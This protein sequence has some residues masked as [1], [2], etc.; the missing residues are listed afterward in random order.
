[1]CDNSCF[2]VLGRSYFTLRRAGLWP[3][4]LFS[5]VMYS[6]VLYSPIFVAY[7]TIRTILRSNYCIYISGQHI[8][9]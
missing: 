9:S 2:T 5:N 7:S 3:F 8:M 6:T 4:L 1:M